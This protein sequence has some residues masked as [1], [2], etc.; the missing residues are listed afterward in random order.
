MTPA[1]SAAELARRLDELGYK[2]VR[3]LEGSLF[4]WANEGRPLYSGDR[5]VQKVHPYDSDWGPLLDPSYH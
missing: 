4:E 2:Q 3:N 5:R 1:S